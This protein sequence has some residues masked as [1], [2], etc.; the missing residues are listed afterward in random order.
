MPFQNALQLQHVL[1]TFSTIM[2]I[3]L[4]NFAD[5][6]YGLQKYMWSWCNLCFVSYSLKPGHGFIVFGPDFLIL[7]SVLSLVLQSSC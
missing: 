7:L 2:H 5:I 4:C 6:V 1:H 3:L